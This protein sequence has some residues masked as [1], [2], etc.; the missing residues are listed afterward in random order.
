M[1]SQSR[2]AC[3]K[4]REEFLA[5]ACYMRKVCSPKES[6]HTLHADA[7]QLMTTAASEK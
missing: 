2:G 1:I 6:G 7:L 4:Q 3:D 5:K